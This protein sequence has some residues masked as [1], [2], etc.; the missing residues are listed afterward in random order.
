MKQN[1]ELKEGEKCCRVKCW[2]SVGSAALPTFLYYRGS[3]DSVSLS[4][5]SLN[6]ALNI[7]DT[8]I[9]ADFE[10]NGEEWVSSAMTSTEMSKKSKCTMEKKK[11]SFTSSV[12]VIIYCLSKHSLFKS[13]MLVVMND[14]R[15]SVLVLSRFTRWYNII[16]TPSILC[17]ALFCVYFSD[18][19]LHD[20]KEGKICGS[21]ADLFHD[22][23]WPRVLYVFNKSSAEQLQC[24][25][26]KDKTDRCRH[27]FT[28]KGTFS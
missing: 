7:F 24:G 13:N 21:E 19:T 3:L 27:L 9:H 20:R 26:R 22:P 6:R 11:E 5:I 4:I 1:S 28:C 8:H 2:F 16:C 18:C 23:W 14:V 12:D 17:D 25:R 10:D 15:H